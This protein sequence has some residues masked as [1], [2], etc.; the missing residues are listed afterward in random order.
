MELSELKIG[1][2][3]MTKDFPVI[4]KLTNITPEGLLGGLAFCVQDNSIRWTRGFKPTGAGWE[5]LWPHLKN[6]TTPVLPKEEDDE[7]WPIRIENIREEVPPNHLPL[8]KRGA[9][10]YIDY[11]FDPKSLSLPLCKYRCRRR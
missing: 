9:L 3:Y 5:E 11:F 4:L 2:F 6:S 10:H 8:F 1:A 7:L